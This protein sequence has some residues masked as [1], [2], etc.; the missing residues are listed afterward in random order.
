[1]VAKC[2]MQSKG[3]TKSLSA[4]NGGTQ[5]EYINKAELRAG[6]TIKD[7]IRT[8]GVPKWHK[9]PHCGKRES[10]NLS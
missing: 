3:D 6:M 8:L 10:L 2:V 5:M 1:M 4:E 7:N 9:C